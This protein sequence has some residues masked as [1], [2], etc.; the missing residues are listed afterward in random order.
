MKPQSRARKL[1]SRVLTTRGASSVSTGIWALAP[2]PESMK[3]C[4]APESPRAERE[5]SRQQQCFEGSGQ[6]TRKETLRRS[7]TTVT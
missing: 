4:S 1:P 6:L 7:S 3:L 5:G 2:K